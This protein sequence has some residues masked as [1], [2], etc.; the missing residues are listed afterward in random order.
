MQRKFHDITQNS[1]DWD[2]LRKCRFTAS[3]FKDLFM[4][5]S[6]AGY[7]DALYKPLFERLTGESP[8]HFYG[9]YMERGHALEP[10]AIE[11]YEMDNFVEI[12]NGGFWSMGDWIGASPDGLIGKDGLFE[13]K[14]P[15]YT[16]HIEYLIKKE[17]PKIYYWQ[18]HGQM[19]V[20]NRN[21]VDFYSFHPGIQPL[22]IRVHRDEKIE[23]ELVIKLNDSIEKASELLEKL[24][25]DELKE[26][27]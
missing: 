17:L 14:A 18:V 11:Q 22:C 4:G 13:G 23:Q 16:T 2:V 19:Y 5:K 20:T 10:Y 12:N 24:S 8:D 25:V 7:R 15:K 9:A 3:S 1:D 26:A 21:W 27:A 6:T